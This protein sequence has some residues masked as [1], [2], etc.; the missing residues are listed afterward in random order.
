MKNSLRLFLVIIVL[1]FAGIACNLGAG[2]TPIQPPADTQVVNNILFQDDFSDP[3]SGWLTLHDGDQLVDYQQ[4]GLRFYITESQF[5]YWSVPNLSFGDVHVEVNATKL[6]G[7]DDNDFGVICRY[8]DEGHFYG[9]LVS[10]DGYYGISKMV[11][12]EHE[13]LGSNNMQPS[14]VINTGAASNTLTVDCIGNTLRLSVNGTTLLEVQ[15][16][17]YASG[18][19]GL[20]AGT[21]D[22]AGVDILFDN[23]IVTKP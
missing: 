2:N 9:F 10:S 13:L 23:F 17:D 19:V 8:K 3:N 14:D 20:L 16:G 6:G 5:D 4:D 7:P 11:D 21:F 22:T 18:D 15:D 12:G 1:G